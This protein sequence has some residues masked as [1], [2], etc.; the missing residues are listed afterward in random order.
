MND[1]LKIE[2]LNEIETLTKPPKKQE[3][4]ITI[5]EFSEHLDIT[6]REAQGRLQSSLNSGKITRRKVLD[7]GHWK[8]AYRLDKKEEENEGNV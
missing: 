5:R 6:Y 4:E 3:D 7:G 1:D 8:W 2:I